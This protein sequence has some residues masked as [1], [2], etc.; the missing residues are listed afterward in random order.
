MEERPGKKRFW[1]ASFAVLTT[2]GL[3][4]DQKARR[5]VMGAALVEALLL[6]VAGSTF[7]REVLDPKERTLAFVLFWI[8]CGWLTILAIL[9]A[10]FDLLL[11]RAQSRAAR[12]VLMEQTKITPPADEG[13][14]NATT[15]EP[16]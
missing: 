6:I 8:A 4:R 1:M 2:R 12:K 16:R 5:V 9:L 7:L 13:E 10:L 11:V 3:I 15:Q 14:G